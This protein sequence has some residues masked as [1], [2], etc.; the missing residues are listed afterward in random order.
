MIVSI[1]R[2]RYS[3]GMRIPP[4]YTPNTHRSHCESTRSF[5]LLLAERFKTCIF[6]TATSSPRAVPCCST[7]K[8]SITIPQSGP[9]PCCLTLLGSCPVA[10]LN[11]IPFYPLLLDREIVWDSI[12]PCWKA[13][14]WW[15]CWRN[16]TT[17]HC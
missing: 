8:P 7:F 2:N 13:K 9:N 17:F 15:A 16:G 3:H 4:I 12:W 6:P 1:V 11:R 14:W 10:R 5:P